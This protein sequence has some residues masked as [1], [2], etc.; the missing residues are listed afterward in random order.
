MIEP[1][2]FYHLLKQNNINFFCGVPD[3][4]LKNFCAYITD[5]CSSK[6]HIISANE[7][8][9]IGISAGKYIATGEIPLVY[10]QNS[11]LG[12]IVNPVM[13]LCHKDV[14][15]I[16]LLLMIGWRGEP[17]LKDEPQHHPQGRKT[18][19]LLKSMEIPFIELISNE[20]KFTSQVNKFL[21]A[22][23]DIKHPIAILVKKNTF[24]DYLIKAKT[25][26]NNNIFN[27]SRKEA[28]KIV[29]EKISSSSLFIATTGKLGRELYQIR[30]EIGITHQNDFLNI[31]A[32]GHASSIALGIS[33]S[34]LS[35]R[36]ICLDGDGSMIMHMGAMAIIGDLKNKNYGHI[37]FNNGKHDSVGGQP[38]VAFNINL[39]KIAEALNYNYS[40]TVS[41][42]DELQ[43]VL[44]NVQNIMGP[45]FIEILIKDGVDNNLG[46]PNLSPKS[47]LALFQKNFDGN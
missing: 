18:V 22:N 29:L 25:D 11:G 8:N 39:P 35:K 12:N 41:N 31:G 10:L 30:D 17:G 9:A 5:N 24:K 7:G 23:K 2:H 36:I 26:K 19:D 13:S 15:G 46:R 32:M 34:S 44:K 47:S 43:V 28:L 42:K 20:E 40:K 6:N 38:T 3:S 37:V 4:L 1:K 14:Y 27:M 45:W 21:E 16:P 33:L